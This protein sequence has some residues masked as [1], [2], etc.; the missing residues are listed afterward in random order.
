MKIKKAEDFLDASALFLY[1]QVIIFFEK[2]AL[3]S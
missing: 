1:N 2:A 3:F